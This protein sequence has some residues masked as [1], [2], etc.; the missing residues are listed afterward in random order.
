MVSENDDLPRLDVAVT[1]ALPVQ[2]LELFRNRHDVWVNPNDRSLT[3]DELQ[4]AAG[5][6]DAMVV[7]A[8]IDW[9]PTPLPN[10]RQGCV[11][12]RPT[13]SESST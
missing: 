9:M 8:L 13:Q 1:R 4:Q 12:L 11:S 3:P 7:T 6:A 10:C 5:G 2:A